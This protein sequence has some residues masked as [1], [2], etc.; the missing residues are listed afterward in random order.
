MTSDIK[1]IPIILCGGEGKRLWPLSNKK[2]TKPFLKIFD[3]KSSFMNILNL[4]SNK[5]GHNT[6]SSPVIICN[7]IHKQLV[8]EQLLE[9]GNNDNCIILTE[10]VSKNTCASV[11]LASILCSSLYKE[12]NLYPLILSSDIIIDDINEFVSDIN[13]IVKYIDNY[14][15]ALFGI[16]PNK[17][18]INFGYIEKSKKIENDVYELSTFHEKPD[19]CTAKTYVSKGYLFNSGIFLLNNK[20]IIDIIKCEQKDIY[21]ICNKS[22]NTKTYK[23][24]DEFVNCPSISFDYAIMEKSLSVIVKEA[25]FKWSDIGTWSNLWEYLSDNN[26]LNDSEE[27]IFMNTNIK[28]DKNNI[29]NDSFP[30]VENYNTEKNRASVGYY[31]SPIGLLQVK[32]IGDELKEINIINAQVSAK[33]DI[34]IQNHQSFDK[35]FAQL[36]KYFCEQLKKYG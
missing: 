8:K 23:I 19:I 9:C 32:K 35:I 24:S 33:K 5:S 17:S 3:N 2:K 7:K 28:I 27:F 30:I 31:K 1:I 10:P 4:V 14:D 16:K 21:D 26:K 34:E 22:L 36:D 18:N 29:Y 25:N 12:R 20:R 13:Q 6:F 15:V 11:T